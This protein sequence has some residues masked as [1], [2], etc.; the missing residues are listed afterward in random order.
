MGLLGE[1]T[2]GKKES[3]D[4]GRDNKLKESQME[5]QEKGEETKRR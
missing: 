3:G 5:R 1:E 2:K 4:A